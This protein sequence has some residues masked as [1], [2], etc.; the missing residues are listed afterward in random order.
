M[1]VTRIDMDNQNTMVRFGFGKHEGH[2][3]LR[4]DL[5]R[6]GFRITAK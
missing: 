3:F 6:V 5:W 2:W 4:L 1:K